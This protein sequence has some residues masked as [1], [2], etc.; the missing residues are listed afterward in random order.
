MNID[1]YFESCDGHTAKIAEVLSNA[2]RRSGLAVALIDL[3]VAQP[4][5]EALNA[6][7]PCIVLAP[8]RY[9]RPLKKARWL[10]RALAP[11]TPEKPVTL[12]CVNLTARKPDKTT[13][14]TN[15][16][17]R[18]WIQGSGLQPVLA[19]AIAG[20]LNYPQYG[21]FDRF[22]I[23]LIMTLSGGPTNPNS[24]IDYTPWDRIEALA[25]EIAAASR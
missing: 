15:P 12:L 3:S 21:A 1:L 7:S 23:R 5:L 19:E 25:S 18:R 10:V 8:I 20:K 24:V 9:G 11:L 13:A 22:M 17:L 14:A 2:I 6:S 16:Y 4:S